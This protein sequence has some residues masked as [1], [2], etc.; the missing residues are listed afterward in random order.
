MS[1][2][3]NFMFY[4]ASV[5][6]KCIVLTKSVLALRLYCGR[7]RREHVQRKQL[8]PLLSCSKAHWKTSLHTTH[9]ESMKH[10]LASTPGLTGGFPGGGRGKN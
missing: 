9:M 7:N 5:E 2:M 1:K 4:F 8:Q 10:Y 3:V 6:T